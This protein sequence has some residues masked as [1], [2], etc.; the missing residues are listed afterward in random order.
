M[1]DPKQLVD[2]ME[3]MKKKYDVNSFH[4][5]DSTF[6]VNNKKLISF[7]KELIDKKFEYFLPITSWNKMRSN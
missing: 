5:M 1:R 7:C 4:F 3:F 2:E 6:I